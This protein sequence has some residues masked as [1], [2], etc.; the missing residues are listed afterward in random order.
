MINR[1][2]DLYHNDSSAA[3]AL[4]RNALYLLP[5]PRSKAMEFCVETIFQDKPFGVH[6]FWRDLPVANATQLK[7]FFNN[8]PEACEVLPENVLD[9][10]W[11][12][13]KLQ[14][15]EEGVGEEEKARR[16]YWKGCLRRGRGRRWRGYTGR[17]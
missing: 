2:A 12:W 1:A 9:K 14:C 8:C 4:L 17:G 13:M 5:A 15:A 7:S 16:R 3:Q 10:R 6:Q 11:E